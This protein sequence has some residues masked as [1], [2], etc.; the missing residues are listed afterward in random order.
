MQSE[1]FVAVGACFSIMATLIGVLASIIF[2][3]IIKRIEKNE[4]D[5]NALWKQL[6]EK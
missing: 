1:I 6:R 3:F 4:R 2:K 5:M